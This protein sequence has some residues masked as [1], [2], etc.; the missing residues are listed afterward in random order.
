[1][2]YITLLLALCFTILFAYDY[3]PAAQQIVKLPV[4]LLVILMIGLMLI[5]LLF[6]KNK[7]LDKKSVLKWKVWVTAYIILLMIV[8]TALGGHSQSG[9]SFNNT[10]FW[11]V[12]LIAVMDIFSDWKK[13]KRNQ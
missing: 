7:N 12:M 8:F 1:M 4:S 10:F 2:K 11:L 5:S 9:I 13:L 3:F 6:S